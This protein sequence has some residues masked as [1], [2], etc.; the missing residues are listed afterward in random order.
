VVVTFALQHHSIVLALECRDRSRKVGVPEVEAFRNKCDRTG[1]HRAVIVSASGFTTTAIKKAEALEIGCLGLEDAD[2][3]DWCLAPGVE[4]F[5]R[6]LLPGLPWELATAEPFFGSPQLYDA[7]GRPL[8]ATA[9]TKLAQTALSARSPEIA[10]EEDRL[11]RMSPVT[12]IFD[13]I[14]ASAFHLIDQNGKKHPLTKMIMRVTYRVRYSL[15]PF[16]FKSYFDHAKARELYTA[17]FA[18]ID[19]KGIHGEL[20]LHHD[21]AV[22]TVSFVPR[23]SGEPDAT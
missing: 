4:W 17:A 21:G 16:N 7:E 2:R 20:V 5:D 19:R 8:D 14:G 11:A 1:V 23:P 22:A 9:F 15:I 12:C 3:F 6:D 13:N 18:T 10:G